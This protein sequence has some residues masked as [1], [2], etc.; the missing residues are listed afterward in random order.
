MPQPPRVPP[1]RPARGVQLI[2]GIV[3]VVLIVVASLFKG[4]AVFYTDFL[5]FQSVH[6]TSVW[7]RILGTKVLLGVVGA[8]FLFA[9][10]WLNIWIADKSAPRAL[11]LDQEDDFVKT[12]K[13]FTRKRQRLLRTVVALIVA[14]LGGVGFNTRWQQWLLFLHGGKFGAKDPQFHK[15]IGFYV[16]KLPFLETL[17]NGLMVSVFVTLLI[18]AGVHYA[19]GAI[20][21][22]RPRARI[23]S[24]VKAHFSVL[25]GVLALLQAVKYYL[26]RYDLDYSTRGVKTGANYTDVH[27]MAPAL[28]LLSLISILAAVVFFANMRQRGWS[29]PAITVVLWGV[30]SLLVGAVIPAGVQKLVVEPSESQKEL[31]YIQRN[32]NA[33]RAA[34][35]LQN[36]KVQNFNYTDNLTAQD[37]QD[38]A[39]TVRNVRLWDPAVLAPSYQRLQETRS[40]FNFPSVDVDRYPVDGQ[41]TQMMLSVRELNTGGIPSGRQS[42]VSEHLQYTHGY[43]A[44]ASPANAVTSDGAPN[45]TL[46]DVPPSGS[47]QVSV[48]QVYFGDYRSPQ[49][50]SIVGTGQPEIDY[51][52]NS[53]D[54]QTSVYHGTGGVPLNNPI[55]KLAFAARVGDLNPLISSL[56]GKHS[57]AMYE[58]NIEARAKK[59]APFLHFD[60]DPYPVILNGHIEWVQDAYTTTAAYPYGQDA[61]DGLLSSGSDLAGTKF[62]YIRNSVKVVTD[63]YNGNMTFYVNDPT[64]PLIK[65]WQKAFPKLF[66]SATQMPFDLR[67]HLRYPED[68]YKVQASAFNQYHMTNAIDFYRQSDR[69]NIAQSPSDAPS[70]VTTS[71]SVLPTGQVVA[72]GE[73]RFEPYYLMMRL[74]GQTQSQYVMFEPF[75]PYSTQDQR[76]ELSAFMTVSSD[77]G[78]YGQI[79]AY[80]MPRNLQVDGPDLVDAHIQQ[81]VDISRQISLLNQ[82][83]SRVQFGDLMIIPINNSLLYV[84]PLYVTAQ[85]TQTPEFKDAIVV[86]GANIAMEPTLQQALTDVFGSAPQ[87]QE[88]APTQS[89]PGTSGTTAGTAPASGSSTTSSTLAPSASAGVKDLLDQANR[90]FN[91]ANTAL[92]NGDLATYQKDVQDGVALVQQA[93]AASP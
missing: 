10:V 3:V 39:Q 23:T 27:L 75:V 68:M 91:D 5:W 1:R 31:P 74:P 6:L 78:Q 20:P 84:R 7:S 46:K 18:A 56:V 45:F 16:F 33:T 37:L 14:L 12:Y 62:N 77:P 93:Q 92:R 71:T 43:G 52:S 82:Q 73:A 60:N 9:L 15:D 13:A 11:S 17:I 88:Q 63:A 41:E 80:V 58:T 90:D 24:A 49:A 65:A 53:G 64:D 2:A 87:T 25:A 66:T 48:P 59:A 69:W 35:D 72:Q 22:G 70:A 34:L 40:F 8:V 19:Q 61:D 83:G 51:V 29:I 44:V 38:N 76:K 85:Q 36:I 30:V 81:D 42:W 50:Y 47:P 26:G 55:K 86:Q 79:N 4:A 32:I 21:I 67:A 54:D 89:N 57:R 28:I